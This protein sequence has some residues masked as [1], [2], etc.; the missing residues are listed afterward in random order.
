MALSMRI[1]PSLLARD[2]EATMRFY[3]GLG[4]SVSG[5]GVDVRWI[6]LAR[7]G[8]VLQFFADPPVGTSVEPVMSGTI[9]FYP[10]SVVALAAEWAHL[11]F[12]WGPEVMD[13][14]MREFGIRDPNGYFLAFTEPA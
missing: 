3:E 9:Y 5:G 4:F 11:K 10:E 14:G 1:T 7:D 8:A 12:E 2:L 6:E 13:Y